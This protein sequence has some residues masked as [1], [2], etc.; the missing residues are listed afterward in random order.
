MSEIE[1]TIST[2][3]DDLVVEYVENPSELAAQA[4]F[5]NKV[6][7]WYQDRSEYGPR[8]LGNRSIIASP[9]NNWTREILN[10]QVK[11]REWFR[12]FAPAVKLDKAFKYFQGSSAVPYM[13][14]VADVTATSYVDILACIHIDGT[15]RLQTV[16]EEDNPLFYKLIDAFEKLSGIPVVLNTSFNLAGMPIVESPLDAIR[17]F[18]DSNGLTHLF[19]GNYVL[20]KRNTELN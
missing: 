11:H 19:L 5:N 13:M 15:S 20:T 18:K 10:H 7:A 12:P 16:S 2:E 1:Q 14:K 8:A 9:Q 4:I 6:I 3:C 17:C